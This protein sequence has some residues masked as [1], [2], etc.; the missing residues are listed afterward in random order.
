[1]HLGG[2]VDDVHV[3]P[4][5]GEGPLGH[6]GQRAGEEQGLHR[7]HRVGPEPAARGHAGSAPRQVVDP[8]DQQRQGKRHVEEGVGGPGGRWIPVADGRPIRVADG[9][10]GQG[11]EGGRAELVLQRQLGHQ[12]DRAEGQGQRQIDLLAHEQGRLHLGRWRG[13]RDERHQ[14]SHE[15]QAHRNAPSPGV[16]CTR[17]VSRICETGWVAKGRSLGERRGPVSPGAVSAAGSAAYRS[18]GSSRGA[19]C[20]SAARRGKRHRRSA[21][22]RSRGAASARWP[23]ACPRRSR[24]PGA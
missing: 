6:V 21:P 12:P 14:D 2:A 5:T 17:A 4:I 18:R 13:S 15:Q 16:E 23:P 22:G 24:R 8:V 7:D 20:R 19:P 1:M 3:G 9:V 10:V 11:I